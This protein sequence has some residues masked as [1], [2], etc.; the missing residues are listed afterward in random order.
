VEFV[1]CFTGLWHL[2][3]WYV[4]TTTTEGT[5][6]C[7]FIYTVLVHFHEKMMTTYRTTRYHNN[8]ENHNT[9]LNR[10]ENLKPPHNIVVV[11][12]MVM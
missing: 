3:V 11:I 2:L 9:S 4:I 6:G 7:M 1:L 5:A 12:R 8:P 10:R